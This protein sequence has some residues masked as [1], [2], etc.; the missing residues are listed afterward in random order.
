M[1]QIAALSIEIIS[2]LV[3]GFRVAPAEAGCYDGIRRGTRVHES[4]S[5]VRVFEESF[6]LFKI[7]ADE[8]F[9]DRNILE[10]EDYHRGLNQIVGPMWKSRKKRYARKSWYAGVSADT[11][12]NQGEL[13]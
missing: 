11:G 3:Q 6:T 10:I 13:R 2:A 5:P 8:H 7:N 4:L 9:Y 1:A 12:M